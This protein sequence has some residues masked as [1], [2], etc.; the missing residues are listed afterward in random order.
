MKEEFIILKAQI[1]VDKKY[2]EKDMI[3]FAEWLTDIDC[4]QA[5]NDWELINRTNNQRWDD[6]C[7]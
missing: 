2:T 5:L 7:G 1:F 3:D 6:Y 4:K